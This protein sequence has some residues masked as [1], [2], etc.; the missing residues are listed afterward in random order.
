MTSADDLKKLIDAPRDYGVSPMSKL[1]SMSGLDALN[2][3]IEGKLPA[4]PSAKLLSFALTKVE[5]GL[6]PVRMHT[7]A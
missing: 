2:A 5:P 4:P 7:Q 3:M 1:T 6:R